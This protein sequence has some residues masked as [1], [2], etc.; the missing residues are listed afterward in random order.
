MI[1]SILYDYKAVELVP[2]NL[3]FCYQLYRKPVILLL[4]CFN[5]IQNSNVHVMSGEW[6]HF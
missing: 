6:I 1:Q 2:Y 3:I 4:K 5:V